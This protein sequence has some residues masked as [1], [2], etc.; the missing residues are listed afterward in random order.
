MTTFLPST[1][2]TSFHENYETEGQITMTRERR[3]I[4]EGL[5]IDV[6]KGERASRLGEG[7]EN[8]DEHY[9]Y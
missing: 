4:G 8:D 5:T 9:L 2:I 7:W 1:L 3:C 6:T